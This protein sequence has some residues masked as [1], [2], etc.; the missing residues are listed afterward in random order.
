MAKLTVRRVRPDEHDA[1]GR[2]TL[3]AYGQLA[4]ELDPGYEHD[5][6]DAATRDNVAEVIVAVDDDGTVIGT[7]TYLAPGPNPLRE[8]DL[9][10]A[11]SFRMLS[12]AP[13]A[14]GRGVG[15]RL[16]E[17]VIERARADGATAV[18]LHSAASMTAAHR[19]YVS[20]GFVREPELDWAPAPGVDLW[21][22]GLPLER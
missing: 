22:F 12:V 4:H 16:T 5:L 6:L 2:V 1:A 7:V 3:A 19:L 14:Q 10:D 21:G 20:M 11:A 9:D 8:H 15:R 17:A 18:V 13:E